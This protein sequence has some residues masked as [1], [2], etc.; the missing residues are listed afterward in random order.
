MLFGQTFG[1]TV[2][3]SQSDGT[4][5]TTGTAASIIPSAARFPLP[6]GYFNRL[7]R[8]MR[9]R[10]SGKVS[11]VVTTPGTMRFDL[12]FGST[13]VWDGL[14]VALSAADAY[15]DLPWWLE[16][17]LTCRGL[18]TAG[19]LIGI[20]TLISPNIAGVSATPPKTNGVALLPWNTAPVVGN[21]FDGNASQIVDLFY[22]QTVSTGSLTCSQYELM[23]PD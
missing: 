5:N 3:T 6:P 23:L 4:P 14:A 2:V 1:E 10:A 12:R 13:V 22:T 21:T 7:G 16:I 15:T 19:V 17:D 18:G 9:I 8:K 11:T 20:G